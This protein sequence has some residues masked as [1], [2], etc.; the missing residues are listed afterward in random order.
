[1]RTR[2]PD[3]SL[4]VVPNETVFA[5]RY[6]KH[7]GELVQAL[8]EEGRDHGV[9]VELDTSE[10]TRPGEARGGAQPITVIEIAILAGIARV[11]VDRLLAIAL[12]WLRRHFSD[13][14]ED[15]AIARIL[16]PDGDVLREV[17]LRE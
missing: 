8:V 5:L 9:S 3:V 16:G 17:R 7:L 10:R 15:D 14:Q 6:E 2:A 1:M 4:Q 11:T 12:A 13:D